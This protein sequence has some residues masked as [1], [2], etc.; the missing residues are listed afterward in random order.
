MNNTNTSIKKD[1]NFKKYFVAELKKHLIPMVVLTV[2]LTTVHA[3]QLFL[4]VSIF[5]PNNF[6]SAYLGFPIAALIAMTLIV[7]LFMFSFKMNARQI[8]MLYSLPIRR[9]K[10]YLVKS[11][12]GLITI[13]APFTIMFWI[14]VLVTLTANIGFNYAG[15]LLVWL[16]GLVLMVF[17]FGF[18]AFIFTRANRIIDGIIIIVVY[19]GIF[20]LFMTY[21]WFAH[22]HVS[23]HFDDVASNPLFYSPISAFVVMGMQ[24]ERLIIRNI[25]YFGSWWGS[26]PPVP[27]ERPPLPRHLWVSYVYLGLTGAAAWFGLFFTAAKFEKAETSQRTSDTLWGYRVIIPT[28]LALAMSLIPMREARYFLLFIIPAALIVGVVWFIIY[29]R[30]VKLKW[31]DL[32]SVAGSVVVGI[33]M[34]LAI[35]NFW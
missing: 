35:W 17:L 32:V 3:I 8:D 4:R 1:T 26:Y 5:R 7:P 21:V 22:I 11:L 23:G 2:M 18:V 13:A 33:I 31:Y 29:R 6:N 24:L 9:E 28:T 16:I 25:P 15:F 20:S 30:T 14:G 12:V 34:S 10:I 27:R 19:L